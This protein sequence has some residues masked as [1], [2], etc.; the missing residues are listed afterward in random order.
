MERM[1]TKSMSVPA[2]LQ[3]IQRDHVVL[4]VK[5]G[6]NTLLPVKA[7][8]SRH[9]CRQL[10]KNQCEHWPR[11]GFLK[12]RSLASNGAN[13]IRDPKGK[14]GMRGTKGAWKGTMLRPGC[15]G[16]VQRHGRR[17]SSMAHNQQTAYQ[18]SKDSIHWC[19]VLGKLLEGLKMERYWMTQ[20]PAETCPPLSWPRVMFLCFFWFY[21]GS[22]AQLQ[23]QEH[24]AH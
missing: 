22:A 2:A 5:S 15:G 19:R 9:F 21:W 16:C 17:S 24:S 6:F 8:N 12:I 20:Y 3:T 7:G 11:R 10:T 4:S 18:T 1:N 23:L 13:S 14:L